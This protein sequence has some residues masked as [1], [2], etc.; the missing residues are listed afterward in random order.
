[1][2]R[3]T[4]TTNDV[5]KPARLIVKTKMFQIATSQAETKKYPES[6]IYLESVTS[7]RGVVRLNVG[8]HYHISSVNYLRGFSVNLIIQAISDRRSFIRQ[9]I[10]LLIRFPPT[11]SRWVKKSRTGTHVLYNLDPASN[12]QRYHCNI[13]LPLVGLQTDGRT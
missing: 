11:S 13:C 4:T 8:R 3:Q 12:Q 2:G 6:L 9:H 10:S 7:T 5:T 1:M